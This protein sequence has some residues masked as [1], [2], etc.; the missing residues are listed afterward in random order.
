MRIF[1]AESLRFPGEGLSAQGEAG[2]KPRSKDVGDG[3]P[4]Q[5]PAPLKTVMSNGVTQEVESTRRWS[6]ASKVVG[7][8]RV[9]CLWAL[10]LRADVE[11]SM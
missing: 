5:I 9:K 11:D 3:Q 7:G 6:C 8:S 10:T 2:P 1:S 4:V